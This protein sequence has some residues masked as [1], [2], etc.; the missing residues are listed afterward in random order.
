MS[1]AD[2][3]PQL[4]LDALD[5][6]GCLK[7][8][9]DHANGLVD[10]TT[11]HGALVFGMFALMAEYEAALIQERTHA[12]LA[13]AR[14]RG[15]RGGRTPKMTP[16]LIGKAQRMYDSRQFTMAEIAA[17]CSVSPMTIYRHIRTDQSATKP[18]DA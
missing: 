7:V 13:A 2:Q 18:V 8:Y 12:G 14:A 11:A 6:A 15:R 4:Q 16:A 3:N 17:S 1:S 5:G 9:T 10:T